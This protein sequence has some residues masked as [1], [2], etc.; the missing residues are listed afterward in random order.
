MRI[1]GAL[2]I[3]ISLLAGCMTVPVE[4]GCRYET[5]VGARGVATTVFACHHAVPVYYGPF[6]PPDVGSNIGLHRRGWWRY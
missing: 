4:P 2:S 3:L 1:V 6:G 5:Y